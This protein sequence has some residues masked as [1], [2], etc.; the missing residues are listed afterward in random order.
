MYVGRHLKKEKKE[1]GYL[2]YP[3]CTLV[4]SNDKKLRAGALEL[5]CT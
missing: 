3:N 2:K 5:Q 1:K 4:R